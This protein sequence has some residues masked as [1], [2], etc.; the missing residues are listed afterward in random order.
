MQPLSN[1]AGLTH[2]SA[3]VMRV[4]FYLEL[5]IPMPL[6]VAG[7]T[8]ARTCDRQNSYADTRIRMRIIDKIKVVASW[9]RPITDRVHSKRASLA[10]NE[11]LRDL[12]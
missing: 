11:V 5:V 12:V 1:A 2:P 6:F 3:V 8:I 10:K 9:T 4:G 7:F